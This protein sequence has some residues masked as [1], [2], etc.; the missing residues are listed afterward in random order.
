MS[1][2]QSINRKLN[3]SSNSRYLQF[4]IFI[5]K[6]STMILRFSSKRN[7]AF[8]EKLIEA[9]RKH[10]EKKN[11]EVSTKRF[12]SSFFI[13]KKIKCVLVCDRE[14][15]TKRKSEIKSKKN[16]QSR[17]EKNKKCDC[18]FKIND[19]YDKHLNA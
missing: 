15:F 14:D 16:D 12:K 2:R 11:Y 19:I 1:S 3:K 17:R 6:I 13:E 4:T 10:V 7:Y 8:L 9:V 18:N 5:F